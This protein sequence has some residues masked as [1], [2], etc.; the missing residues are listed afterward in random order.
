MT[1]IDFLTTLG[2]LAG[3]AFTITET[4]KMI[5]M[6]SRYAGLVSLVMGIVLA[7]LLG[8]DISLGIAAGLSAAGGYSTI[9][10]GV[11]EDKPISNIPHID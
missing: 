3:G 6:P 8:L 11:K 10:A 1:E 7:L 9:K 2:G 5:G 4:I